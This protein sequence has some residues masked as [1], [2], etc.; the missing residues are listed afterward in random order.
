MSQQQ[1]YFASSSF[2]EN[3]VGTGNGYY[4]NQPVFNAKQGHGSFVPLTGLLK[5]E[6]FHTDQNNLQQQQQA[7][8]SKLPRKN[9][10]IVDEFDLKRRSNSQQQNLVDFKMKQNNQRPKGSLSK[11]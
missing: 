2:Q 9:K 7:S 6:D 4:N 5:A 11:R 8:S 10:K 3:A 1:Q